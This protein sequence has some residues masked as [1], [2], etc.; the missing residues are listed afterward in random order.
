LHHVNGEAEN[1]QNFTIHYRVTDNDGDSADSAFYIEV[2]DDTPVVSDNL[3][4]LLDD[5]ALAGGLADGMGDVTPDQQ[6]VSGVLSYSCGA[7]GGSLSWLTTGSPTGFSYEVNAAQLRIFQGEVN[8][9]TL[10]M[11]ASSGAYTVVQNAPVTH[12]LGGQENNQSFTVGYQVTDEDGDALA[13]ELVIVVNDDTPVVWNATGVS[14]ANIQNPSP[15]GSGIF[16]YAL[17]ADQRSTYS[18]TDSDFAMFSFTG[19]VGIN[20]I[21]NTQVAWVSESNSAALFNFGFDYQ[22]LETSVNTAHAQGTLSFDK[23]NGTYTI[24]MT[25]PI[26]SFDI[27][28]TSKA[29]SFIGYQLESAATDT[30]QPHV[31]VAKLSDNVHA[32]FT[33]YSEPGGGT[34]SNNLQATGVDAGTGSFVSGEVFSQTHDWVSTS[35]L[36]NGVGGDTLQKGEVLDI[37]LFTS[38]PLGYT[39]VLATEAASALFLK[40][41]GVGTEDLV[42]LLKLESQSSLAKTTRALIVE[43]AD[44]LKSGSSLTAAYQLVLDNNDGAV[45]FE[46]ND[47]NQAGEDYLITGAQILTSTE[48]ISGSGINYNSAT[49]T[50][51]ASTAAQS[52]GAATTDGDVIKISD[53][54]VVTAKTATL[55]AHL[56]FSFAV[57]DFDGD[58]SATQHLNILIS[59]GAGSLL[60]TLV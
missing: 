44:I 52:F 36:A 5:D 43:S 27:L 59:G 20:A 10:E 37:D 31:S 29:L 56:D 35:N 23:L 13:G 21:T 18:S 45:I 9:I 39:T 2:N 19:A 58:A 48:G 38:N 4:I 17:G 3:P 22:P 57:Q 12:D 42:V 32:Q 7:D 47:Y 46:R 24:S 34:G 41:D 16:A 55:D 40:F 54:G 6:N 28:T 15:G 26:D 50:L 1:N 8:V 49:G 53:I 30:T 25:Q 14:Y 33:A 11:D 51:G 60:D